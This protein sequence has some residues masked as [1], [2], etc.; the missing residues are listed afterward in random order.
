MTNRN[1]EDIII[2]D[3]LIQSFS[4]DLKNGIPIRS[5]IDD[6]DDVEL[7]YIADKLTSL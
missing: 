4:L 6:G 5:Y 1:K 3:N 7:K 2:I